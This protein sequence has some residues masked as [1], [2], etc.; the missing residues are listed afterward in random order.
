MTPPAARIDTGH[1]VLL[2]TP[3]YTPPEAGRSPCAPTYDVFALGVLLYR[4]LTGR[5]PFAAPYGASEGQ[6]ARPFA[7]LG[8]SHRPP[9][10]LQ[11]VLLA[12]LSTSPTWRLRSA[13]ELADE[14]AS[15]AAI[16]DECDDA[17]ARSPRHRGPP[18]DATTRRSRRWSLDA[19]GLDA[20]PDRPPTSADNVSDAAQ[21]P[22][23]AQSSDDASHAA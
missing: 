5:M 17:S 12:A 14:L 1:G 19:E 7:E 8:L 3:G 18:L 23:S 9:V 21:R 15:A 10:A 11:E 22:S 6:S 4:A 20:A 13:D 16:L 2:G